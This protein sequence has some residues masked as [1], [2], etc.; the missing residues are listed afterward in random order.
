ML[1]EYCP[2]CM[3]DKSEAEWRASE[4]GIRDV[5]F[6][7]CPCG[8]IWSASVRGATGYVLATVGGSLALVGA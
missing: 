8:H 7:K 1:R 3:V 6:L 5:L 4:V 2:E